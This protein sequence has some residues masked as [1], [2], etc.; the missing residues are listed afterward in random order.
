MK[1]L[2]KNNIME[3]HQVSVMLRGTLWGFTGFFINI[4]SIQCNMKSTHPTEVSRT[5]TTEAEHSH[6]SY[7]HHH[8]LKIAEI[9]GISLMV[10]MMITLGCVIYYMKKWRA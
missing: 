8:K 2:I 4:R 9:V 3:I 10:A 5:L 6:N 7:P 1:S